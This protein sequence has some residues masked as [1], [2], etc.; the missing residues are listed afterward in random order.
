MEWRL[1]AIIVG[2]L[3]FI[4]WI[5]QL[6]TYCLCLQATTCCSCS[7]NPSSLPMTILRWNDCTYS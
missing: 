6:L 2:V 3:F 1:A 7:N 4:R 5:C